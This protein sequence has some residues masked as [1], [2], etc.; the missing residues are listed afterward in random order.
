MRFLSGAHGSCLNPLTHTLHCAQNTWRVKYFSTPQ[1]SEE[2]TLPAPV[3]CW[4]FGLFQ[5]PIACVGRAEWHHLIQKGQTLNR[6]QGSACLG[7]RQGSQSYR[8]PGSLRAH[9]NLP[10]SQGKRIGQEQ[11]THWHR[12]HW[13][14]VPLKFSSTNQGGTKSTFSGYIKT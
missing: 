9:G 13:N 8:S 7:I 2:N 11:I 3:D 1:R 6:L 10:D 4:G 5:K 14:T 12:M